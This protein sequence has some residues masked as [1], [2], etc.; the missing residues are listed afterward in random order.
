[1]E[2]SI[3]FEGEIAGWETNPYESGQELGQLMAQFEDAWQQAV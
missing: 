1:M 3:R 2:K